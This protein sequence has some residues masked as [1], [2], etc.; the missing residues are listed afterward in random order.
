MARLVQPEGR[1]ALLNPSERM[2]IA[3]AADLAAERG[4]QGL[5][6]ASLCE[7]AARAEAH[8]RWDAGELAALFKAAGLRLEETTI[9]M[10]P[11]LARLAMGKPATAVVMS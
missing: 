3:A 11:G 4:L 7:W 5:E 8:H 10:G 2:S 6:R 1:V 9:K